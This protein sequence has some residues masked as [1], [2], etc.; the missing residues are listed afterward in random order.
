MASEVENDGGIAPANNKNVNNDTN[1]EKKEDGRE[2]WS[3]RVTFWLAAVGSAVGLGNLWR[4]PWQCATWGG[5]AFIF[6]YFMCLFTLGLFC[7]FL[8]FRKYYMYI[9]IS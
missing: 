5:G 6:A 7:I 1:E 9:Q 8:Y 3:G 4:F 2:A